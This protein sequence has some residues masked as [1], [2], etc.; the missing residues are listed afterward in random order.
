MSGDLSVHSFVGTRLAGGGGIRARFRAWRSQHLL[1]LF[2]VLLYR[3]QPPFRPL[4]CGFHRH[5]SLVP[6]LDAVHR[7]P[8]SFEVNPAVNPEP[9]A[10]GC[11]RGGRWVSW[12]LGCRMRLGRRHEHQDEWKKEGRTVDQESSHGGP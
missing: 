5:R 11:S 3:S 4:G 8:R 12:H 1:R 9:P 6:C 2:E 7:P 10:D